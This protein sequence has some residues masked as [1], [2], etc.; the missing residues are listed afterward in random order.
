MDVQ[1]RNDKA[2]QFILDQFTSASLLNESDFENLANFESIKKILTDLIYV[3]AKGFR[4]IVATA[5]TGKYL[6]SNY[7]FLNDF[8]ACSPRSIFEQGIFYAFEE[9]RIPCGKSDP[10]NVAKNINV[11]DENWAKG[12]RPAKAALAA[13]KF[14]RLVDSE[15][16]IEIKNQIVNYF[17]F[18]LLSYAKELGAIQIVV[19][20]ANINTNQ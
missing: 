14:L 6:D 7:D 4:G 13:V 16:D 2:K 19:P 12:K 10:L 17:F 20:Q 18:M 1:E 11:L 9:M 8:Y 15:S 5:L 3:D